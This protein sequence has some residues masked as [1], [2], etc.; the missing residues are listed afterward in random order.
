MRPLTLSP[1][2]ARQIMAAQA[3]Q[4]SAAAVAA[5][6][7]GRGLEFEITSGAQRAIM[8]PNI[9]YGTI[10]ALCILHI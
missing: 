9:Q 7:R 6:N 8:R 1:T 4:A 5:G 3:S 2:R 10:I